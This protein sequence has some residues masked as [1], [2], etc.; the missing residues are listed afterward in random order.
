MNELLRHALAEI[1]TRGDIS[2][3]DLAGEI[4]TV[5]EVEASADLRNAR[6]YV[7]PLGGA[8]QEQVVAA[9]R[10]HTR[11]L[12]GELARKVTLK[13]MPA[14]S[15]E[16]D[17]RFDASTRIEALLRSGTVARDLAGGSKE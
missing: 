6:V 2:D 14:L 5:T 13:Y 16:L 8:K 12:R 3:Q 4:V 10:R 15:F 9:L 1:L 17:K 11:F 7:I